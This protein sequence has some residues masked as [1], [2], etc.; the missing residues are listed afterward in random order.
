[1]YFYRDSFQSLV[2]NRI[3][4]YTILS[5]LLLL[6]NFT[7]GQAVFSDSSLLEVKLE[8]G[9]QQVFTDISE[10][11]TYHKGFLSY[12][13]NSG[14][15]I[16][17]P[18]EIRTRG[19]FRRKA[20]NCSQPPLLIKFKPKEISNSVFEG[21]EKLKMVVPCQKSNI[22]E[23]LVLKE[24]LVYKLYQII[25]P[26]SYR[27][28][29]L[30]LKMVDR[31]YGNQSISYAF[32]IEPVEM[33]AK[34]L[35]GVVRDAKNT[36]PNACNSYYY[37]RMAVFQFMIGQTDWSI[38]ALHNI[39]LIEPEPYAPPIPVPFDFDFSG[40]VDSPYA[41]PADHLP[42]KSV[43]ERHFNG[44]CKPEPQYIDAFNYFL[45]LNDTI[46]H[47]INT[48]NYLPQKQRN[49]LIKFTGEFFDIIASDT[50]RKS[51]II[52]KC[53]TD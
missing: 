2:L 49:E 18:V 43:K 29:L 4:S 16:S 25:S 12:E 8:F 1:M 31:Y 26:Y 22:Y 41:L 28:R 3:A 52:S 6:S 19:I 21:I 45:S 7:D 46:S 15:T 27:V 35:G 37:K 5:V 14:A 11:P 10:N 17:I 38:K 44:Y 40:F 53:R 30:R 20:S 50:K 51:M 32:I 34:R 48:F 9:I 42:I 33:L 23:Q 13:D 47:T 24:Y 36:H 39:T